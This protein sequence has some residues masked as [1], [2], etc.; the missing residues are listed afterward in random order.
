[1]TILSERRTAQHYMDMAKLAL[2]PEVVA[3]LRELAE[4]GGGDGITI[5]KQTRANVLLARIDRLEP[6]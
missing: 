2:W 6:K 5:P 4:D 1:M 3:A